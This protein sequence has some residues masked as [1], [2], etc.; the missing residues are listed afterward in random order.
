MTESHGGRGR[1]VLLYGPGA[2][3]GAERTR[4]YEGWSSPLGTSQSNEGRTHFHFM[5]K[6]RLSSAAQL[7]AKVTHTHV[8]GARCRGCGSGPRP[9][10]GSVGPPFPDGEAEA[11]RANHVTFLCLDV[12]LWPMGTIMVPTTRG[13]WEKELS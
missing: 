2:G 6:L 11:L 1:D 12:F 4:P 10:G 5:G 9:H 7:L 13:W 3:P 8:A